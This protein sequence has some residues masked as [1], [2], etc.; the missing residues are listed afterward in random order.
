[1]IVVSAFVV[2]LLTIV[3]ALTEREQALMNTNA[4]QSRQ[5]MVQIPEPITNPFN[6]L[7]FK[8]QNL[9]T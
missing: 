8:S 7:S 3:C 9:N 2:A 5:T 4:V 6:F 1:M